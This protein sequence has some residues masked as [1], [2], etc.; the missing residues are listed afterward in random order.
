MPGETDT[1]TDQHDATV[2]EETTE[3]VGGETTALTDT[4]DTGDA[5]DPEDTEVTSSEDPDADQAPED[6]E[7]KR[8]IRWSQVLAFGVLP[9]LVLL[10]AVAAGFLKWQDTSVR[11]SAT[12]RSASVAAA[13]DGTI[14]LLS[15]QPTTV[16]KDLTAARNRLTGP[17]KDSYAQLTH[18]VVIPGAQQQHIAAL[19]TVPAAASVSAT[20]NHAVV[21]V[22]VNQTTAVGTDQPTDTAS[23]VRVTLDNVNGRW[24]ISGFDPV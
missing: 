5:G 18:D 10:L 23:S 17:F 8:R 21:L 2:D 9:G 1:L 4:G 3:S 22:F 15:Y 20:P 14:A 24:L 6:G 13:K 11:T 16:E 7:H 12:A 19:A